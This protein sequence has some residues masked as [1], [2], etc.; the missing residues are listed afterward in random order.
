[1]KQW[2]RTAVFGVCA[3]GAQMGMADDLFPGGKPAGLA[4]FAEVKSL[5]TMGGYPLFT[6]GRSWY[7][8]AHKVNTNNMDVPI[9]SAQMV[10]PMDNDYFAE[11]VVTT[12]LGGGSEDGYFSADLCNPGTPHLFMLN[13]GT[14]RNDNCL[15]IDPLT[16]KIG[17]VDTPL[18]FIKVRNSQSNWRLYDLSVYLSLKKMGFPNPSVSDWSAAAV[19]ADPQKQ[20]TIA[21]VVAWGRQLQDAVN[22]AIGFSKPQN[23][24]DN[25]PAVYTLLRAD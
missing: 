2:I 5:T 8:L 1:M 14:G 6:G 18:L 16:A 9:A 4:S 11:M 20:Q 7:L 12:S 13:K 24:F 19:A 15:L 23:A 25:V 21:K 3:V 22:T 17:E 10:S